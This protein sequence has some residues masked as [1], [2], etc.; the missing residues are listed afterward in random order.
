MP[1]EIERIRV[2]VIDDHAGIREGIRA[3]LN[4]QPDMIVAGEAI[5]GREAIEQFRTLRPDISI[6]DWNLPLFSGEEVIATL[7]QEFPQA[8]F[9]VITAL[10]DNNCMRR[11]MGLGAQAFLR[12]EALRR[13]LPGTIRAVDAG[14]QDIAAIEGSQSKRES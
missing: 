8:R 10:N 3:L 14:Q 9:I 2:F 11:A 6:V 5:D 7:R 1:E 4:V 13:E 12:K